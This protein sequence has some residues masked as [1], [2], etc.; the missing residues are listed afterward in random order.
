MAVQ[1]TNAGIEGLTFSDSTGNVYCQK[2]FRCLINVFYS[3]V[4]NKT[5]EQE[6]NNTLNVLDITI[7]RCNVKSEWQLRISVYVG[8]PEPQIVLFP[9]IPATNIPWI[10]FY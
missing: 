10:D 9:L 1:Y 8:N 2:W 3:Y 7:N 6:Q 5:L 4:T